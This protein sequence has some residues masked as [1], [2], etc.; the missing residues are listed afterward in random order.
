MDEPQ[1][2]GGNRTQNALKKFKPLFVL[3]YSATHAVKHNLIYKLD[4]LDAYNEKLVKKIEVK[5]FK[6]TNLKGVDA[7]L[8]L[9]DVIVT[10]E[11]PK[12]R[13]ELEQ[14]QKSSSTPKRVYM[15][16][17]SQYKNDLYAL[18]G[19]MEQYKGYTIT[20][21]DKSLQVVFLS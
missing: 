15:L 21:V 14:R 9:N 8:Y 13:I 16:L 3:N 12:A 10:P 17:D 6:V 2:M 5:G 4:A 19:E 18:S 1:K 7:Y 11:G 20:D